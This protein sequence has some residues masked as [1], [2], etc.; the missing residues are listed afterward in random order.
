MKKIVVTKGRKRWL[1]SGERGHTVVSIYLDGSIFQRKVKKSYHGHIKSYRDKKEISILQTSV[2]G[3]GQG[4][5]YTRQ[6]FY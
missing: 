3:K 6:W 4:I 5:E 2:E 1:A